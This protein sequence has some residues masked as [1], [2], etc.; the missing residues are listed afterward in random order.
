M[1]VVNVTDASF[2]SEV[3][4]SE[5]PVLVDL[6]AEWCG[7]CK[8]M[9]PV[10]DQLARELEG[11][12]KFAKVDVDNNPRV[13]ASFR[14]QSIPM[15]VVIDRGQIAGHHVG[16]L[17]KK[18]MMSLLEPFLPA[19]AAEL[20]PNELAQLLAQRRALAVDIR[21]ER[22]FQRARIPAA[23][24]VPQADVPT[25]A[26]ELVANDGRIR[27]LY[28]RTDVE[29]KEL[30]KKLGDSGIEVGFLAGGLL[31]WEAD[32]LPVEKG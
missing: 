4:R 17:D 15:L 31:H 29:A 25:R 30:A 24:H 18:G 9:A 8:Q 2:E 12:I 26:S 11:K 6:W 10:I 22:S 7:P 32:G 14:V 20:K 5:I 23:I 27:V 1:A 19:E 3:L 16:A 13:A 28:G 21:D